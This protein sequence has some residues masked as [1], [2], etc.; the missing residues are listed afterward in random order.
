MTKKQ[1]YD[2][3]RYQSHREKRLAHDKAYYES[4]RAERLAYSKVYVQNPGVKEQ[5]RIADRKHSQKSE[6]KEKKRAYMSRPEIKQKFQIYQRAHHLRTKYGLTLED[7][8]SILAAQGFVCAACKSPFWGSTGPVIDHDHK[9]G[10]VRGILCRDCN[11]AAGILGDDPKRVE[12][13]HA[14][15]Q[16]SKRK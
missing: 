14:Y 9:S 1:A 13:L 8:N 7:F 16:G 11:L 12:Q 5:H 4:H 10:I 15:L 3:A 6:T 2:K